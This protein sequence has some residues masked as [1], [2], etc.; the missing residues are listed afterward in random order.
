MLAAKDLQIERCGR[1]LFATTLNM[2]IEAGQWWQIVGPNGSGKTTLLKA[3][4]GLVVPT[5]GLVTRYTQSH[6]AYLGHELGLKEELTVLENLQYHWQTAA[7]PKAALSAGLQQFFPEA[8]SNRFARHLSRGQRQRLALVRTWLTKA[9]LWLLDEPCTALDQQAQQQ[10][11]WMFQQH[12][13]QGGALVMTAH[14]AMPYGAC[15]LW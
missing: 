7:I 9:P 5:H 2:T 15:L 10:V 13:A 14:S 1:P 11:I 6:V 12:L 8:V 3:L 4:A